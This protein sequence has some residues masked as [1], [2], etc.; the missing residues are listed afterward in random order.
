MLP[1]AGICECMQGGAPTRLPFCLGAISSI[2]LE[3]TIP[4]IILKDSWIHEFIEPNR[5]LISAHGQVQPFIA[6]I[7]EPVVL[8]ISSVVGLAAVPNQIFV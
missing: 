4:R 8:D 1:S 2:A 7:G 5:A 6:A 3:P